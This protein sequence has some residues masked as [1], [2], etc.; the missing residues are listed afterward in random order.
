MGSHTCA[1]ARDGGGV[2]PTEGLASARARRVSSGTP[3]Y[4]VACVRVRVGRADLSGFGTPGAR[5]TVQMIG[6]VRRIGEKRMRSGV[7]I[8]ELTV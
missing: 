1:C 5:L 3:E 6:V 7:E 2:S 8:T 4:G